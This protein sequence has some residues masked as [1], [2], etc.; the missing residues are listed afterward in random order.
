MG[1]FSQEQERGF[2]LGTELAVTK[3]IRC[4]VL[5]LGMPLP[6]HPPYH[7]VTR[8]RRSSLATGISSWTPSLQKYELN[9][10]LFFINRP[11]LGILLQHQKVSQDKVKILLTFPCIHRHG[12]ETVR[13][14]VS[15]FNTG[16]A[17]SFNIL[18]IA[19]IWPPTP[20]DFYLSIESSRFISM[21]RP[22]EVSLE[23]GSLCLVL[24][25]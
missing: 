15:S 8:Q 2:A 14:S 10:L 11:V 7:Q 16:P 5:S 1:P 13:L 18:L 20:W 12:P 17:R 9:K 23:L 4:T 25:S 3:P 22:R 21:W 19:D 6:A 24:R